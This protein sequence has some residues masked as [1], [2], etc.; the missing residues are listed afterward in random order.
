[1]KIISIENAQNEDVY[2]MEVEDVHCYAATKSNII[3]H[4]CDSFRYG[5]MYLQR[6]DD[7]SKAAINVGI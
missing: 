2:N 1:M 7:I 6:K 5:C 4:N 3:I